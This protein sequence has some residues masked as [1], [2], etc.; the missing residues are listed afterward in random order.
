LVRAPEG[1]SRARE[2]G[3]SIV[4]S[5]P[6]SA[7]L[8]SK[9]KSARD[10]SREEKKSKKVKIEVPNGKVVIKKEKLTDSEEEQKDDKVKKSDTVLL[11]LRCTQD[12][13]LLTYHTFLLSP[14][15]S[16]PVTS[17][18]SFHYLYFYY[19]VTREQEARLTTLLRQYFDVFSKNELG[20]CV[21]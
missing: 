16:R 10:S 6:V 15:P 14:S 21:W 8:K 2:R 17:H 9:S 3:E 5:E 18:Y 12:V 7:W 13:L 20:R 4:K 11:A 19:H 1:Q